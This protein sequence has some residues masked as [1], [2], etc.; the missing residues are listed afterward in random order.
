MLTLKMCTNLDLYV[1]FMN[2][3]YQYYHLLISEI[4]VERD[5]QHYIFVSV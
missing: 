1:N 5:I 4:F 3:H 2:M